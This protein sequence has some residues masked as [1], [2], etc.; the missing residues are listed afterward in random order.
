MIIDKMFI[1]DDAVKDI[2]PN[3]KIVFC[4]RRGRPAKRA[5]A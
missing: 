3:L 4:V 2:L 1:V 5:A